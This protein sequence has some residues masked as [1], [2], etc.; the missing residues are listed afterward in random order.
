MKRINCL[1]VILVIIILSACNPQKQSDSIFE[2]EII[3]PKQSVHIDST[4]TGLIFYYPPVDSV[5]LRCFVRPE[6]DKDP[7]AVFCCA[8]AFTLD[9]DTIADHKR[10]CSSHVTGGVYYKKPQ[11][12]RYTGAFVAYNGEWAFLY[13]KDAN[14]AAFD[15]A[16]Q[17]AAH[18]NG[19]GFAQE[20]MIHQGERVPT[21]RPAGNINL[22]RALCERDGRLCIADATSTMQFGAFIELLSG[23]GVTEAIYTDMGYGWNYSWYRLYSGGQATYIHKQ[24]QPAATN[25]LVFYSK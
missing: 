23:C 24:Y 1:S 3:I 14:P 8:A 18:N 5:E 4:I 15:N 17:T 9:Y 22:F 13:D 25:W 19:A 10:I 7:N 2:P 20:M 21:T 6:P 16:F 12:S 11:T